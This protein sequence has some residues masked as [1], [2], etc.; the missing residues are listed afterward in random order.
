[1]Q[2]NRQFTVMILIVVIA[3]VWMASPAGAGDKKTTIQLLL[4]EGAGQTPVIQ[5]QPRDA[6]IWRNDPDKPDMVEWW[7]ES[8]FTSYPEI[9]WEIRHNS[10]KGEGTVDHFGDVDIDCGETRVMAQ[11][12]TKPDSPKVEWPYSITVYACKDGVKAQEIATTDE[13]RIIWED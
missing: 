13:P 6:K 12:K 4:A 7:C 10:S 11:P 9:F 8:N 1:M 5:F 2:R 3:I